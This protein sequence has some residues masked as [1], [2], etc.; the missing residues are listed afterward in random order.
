MNTS[1]T[2]THVEKENDSDSSEGTNN[3]IIWH[4]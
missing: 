2:E 1:S 3:N 4:Y